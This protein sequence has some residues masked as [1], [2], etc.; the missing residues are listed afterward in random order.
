MCRYSLDNMTFFSPADMRRLC[1]I[2]AL[3]H[4]RRNFSLARYLTARAPLR[5]ILHSTGG[6]ISPPR[7]SGI[8]MII[9][10]FRRERVPSNAS[11]LKPKVGD[12]RVI[13]R[14]TARARARAEEREHGTRA[15]VFPSYLPRLSP[16][17]A[18]RGDPQRSGTFLR[19]CV[20]IAPSLSLFLSRSL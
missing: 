9:N 19:L 13:L 6:S 2:F 20:F 12:R 7:S 4:P 18:T 10:S 14:H 17:C 16:T 11:L 1:L 5:A 15:D 8:T 3:L